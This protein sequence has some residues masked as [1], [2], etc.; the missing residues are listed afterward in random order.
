[1]EVASSDFFCCVQK[2]ISISVLLTAIFFLF[3]CARVSGSARERC[4]GHD[5][6]RGAGYQDQHEETSAVGFPTHLPFNGENLLVLAAGWLLELLCHA[7]ALSLVASSQP[8]PWVSAV[9]V[10][11]ERAEA[12]LRFHFC[13]L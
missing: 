13:L 12:F 1:M 11:Q 2:F 8:P 5:H 9:S 4:S 3:R 10:T 6:V 7:V